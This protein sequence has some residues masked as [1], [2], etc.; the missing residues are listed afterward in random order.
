MR[1]FW[2]KGLRDE[3]VVGNGKVNFGKMGSDEEVVGNRAKRQ[4]SGGKLGK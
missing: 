1:Q 3:V 4:G 2:G